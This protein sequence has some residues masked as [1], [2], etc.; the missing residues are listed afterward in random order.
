MIYKSLLLSTFL[1]EL[2]EKTRSLLRSS[3]FRTYSRRTL[4][5]AESAADSPLSLLRLILRIIAPSIC[6]G[7]SSRRNSHSVLCLT[8]KEE[9]EE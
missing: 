7:I 4:T 8:R 1:P 3:R 6:A 5:V 9:E 2:A